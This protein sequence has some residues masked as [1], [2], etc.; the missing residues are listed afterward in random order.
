MS[1]MSLKEKVFKK[2][3]EL[4]EMMAVEE[5]KNISTAILH[6]K[7]FLPFKNLCDNER[8]VVVCGAGPTLQQYKPIEG[9]VHIALNRAFLY[10]KVDFDFI[11]AQDFDGIRMVQKEL[12]DYKGN[13]CVKLLGTQCGG[14]K[15]IPESLALKCGAL[16]FN[17]DVY[18]YRNGN[19]SQFVAD[20]DSRPVGNMSDVGIAAMQ[21]AL[22]L[23]PSVLYIVGCDMS[24][25]HFSNKNQSD[26]EKKQEDD[27][28]EKYWKE[29][30]DKKIEQWKKMKEFAHTYY[31]DTR[32][33]SVN[34]V[35]LKGLFEDMYQ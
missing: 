30:Y 20:I 18:I 3:L 14:K 17:T 10:E 32:I 24:G 5:S 7:T 21:F 29:E 34:P 13:Q 1:L 16:R 28:Q 12:I 31:P 11:Y 2:V 15:E 8:E 25:G 33:V 4:M 23:N 26:L 35:G 6:Q 22:Y 27:A 9:A 19:K